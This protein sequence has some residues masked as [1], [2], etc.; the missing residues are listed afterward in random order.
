MPTV[1]LTLSSQ[2]NRGVPDRMEWVEVR[3]RLSGP[4]H[5]GDIEQKEG[6][7]VLDMVPDEYSIRVD[8]PGF[9]S[10]QGSLAV[11][12]KKPLARTFKLPHRCTRLPTV[13]QL[14]SEQRRLLGTLDATKTPGEIWGDL[15]DNKAATLFQITRA[16]EDVSLSGG[17]PL[18]SIVKRIVRV[19][20]ADL[21]APDVSGKMRSVIGWRLHVLFEQGVDVSDQLEQTGFKRDDGEAHP[22]H[23]RFGFVRSYREKGVSPALQVVLNHEESGADVDLDVGAFHRSAPHDVFKKFALRFPGVSDIYEVD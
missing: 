18:S 23:R 11:Q 2:R 9:G 13:S 20:G 17:G 10:A 3:G 7:L 8:V 4:M 1:T 21:K 22:T 6:E 14:G 12:A 5:P 15:S 19:G 16:L